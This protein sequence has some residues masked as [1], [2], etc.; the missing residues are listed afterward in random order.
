[1][2]GIDLLEKIQAAG[3]TLYMDGIDL[4]VK[5]SKEALSDV[6]IDFIKKN[7]QVLKD[8]LQNIL[9]YRFPGPVE[10]LKVFIAEKQAEF[11]ALGKELESLQ[12]DMLKGKILFNATGTAEKHRRLLDLSRMIDRWK[13]ELKELQAA[14]NKAEQKDTFLQQ[15]HKHLGGSN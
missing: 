10:A 6:R 14:P 2:T 4:R 1:M 5:G 8:T 11:D 13:R 7:Q 3:V 9:P 12:I 15:W